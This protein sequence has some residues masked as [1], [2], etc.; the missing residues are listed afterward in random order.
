MNT[1][2]LNKTTKRA[3]NWIEEYSNS[4]CYSVRDFYSTRVYRKESIEDEIKTRLI[5]NNLIGYKIISGNSFNFTCGYITA[6]KKTLFIET[7]SNI[8]E[9]EL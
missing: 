1:T 5:E 3:Q 2:K 6:D 4:S 9:I 7:V 8:F